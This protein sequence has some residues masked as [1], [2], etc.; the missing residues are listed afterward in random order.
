MNPSPIFEFHFLQLRT[1]VYHCVYQTPLLR[2]RASLLLVSVWDAVN[3]TEH[4]PAP[5]AKYSSS[6]T[7]KLFLP[8]KY[9]SDFTIF[10]F[11]NVACLV[12]RVPLNQAAATP[13]V[14]NPALQTD[15]LTNNI[16][17]RPVRQISVA[18]GGTV[19]VTAEWDLFLEKKSLD[20]TIAAWV[21]A[22]YGSTCYGSLL[23]GPFL[24]K[25]RQL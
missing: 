11:L 19:Q 17:V 18:K 24:W 12:D 1:I 10:S 7:S 5:T 3:K 13:R 20:F 21:R 14:V 8:T 25:S 23:E 4:D 15:P 6:S 16:F 22:Q 2:V 9:L